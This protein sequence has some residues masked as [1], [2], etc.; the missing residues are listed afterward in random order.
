[1]TNAASQV[2][3]Y[4][5]DEAGNQ[6]TQI[7]AL[8]RT[9]TYAYDGLGRRVSHTLPGGQFEGF[10]YDLAGNQIY[11]TNFNGA[12]ITNQFNAVNRLTNCS[13]INGYHVRFAYSPTGQRTNLIDVSGT[14]TYA[15]DV[16][17][18]LVLK[19]NSWNNGP[20]IALNYS[21]DA[22]GNVTNIWSSTVNG[23]N[24]AYSYDP[25]NRLT[26]VLANGSAAAGY[27]FD[28]AGNLQATRYGNGVTNLC[29]YDSL[30]R[31]TSLTWKLNAG[32]LANFS[33]L[34]G[35]TGNRTNLT[36]SVNGTNRVYAWQ[37]DTL[38]RLTNENFNVSSNLAYAYDVVGNRT[39]R[40][41]SMSS[42]TNQNFT[43]NTND[44]LTTDH[45]DN[46]GN[47]TNSS[48]NAYQYDVMNHLTNLNGTV[49][50]TYDGD[51]NRVS[52]TTGGTNTFYLV[53]DL[54][55]SG[56]A[57]V[58][59]EWT[60]TT[61]ATNVSKVYNYGL[62][63]ISQRAPGTSTNYFV[64]DGHGS[65]RLLV[66][67]GGNVQ[68]LFAYDAYGTLIASNASPQTLYLYSGQ[69][70]DQ[71]LGLYYNRAR[72]L[73]EGTGRFWTM[74]TYAGD[75]EDPLSLHKYLYVW[76][77]PVNHIDPSGHDLGD[78]I[79]SMSIQASMMAVRFA[80]VITV[81]R[82][83]AAT[84]FVAGMTFD[85]EFRDNAMAM[86]PDAL[87]STA[88]EVTAVVFELRGMYLTQRTIQIAAPQA[89]KLGDTI[90]KGVDDDMLVHFAPVEAVKKIDEEGI[91]Y[92]EGG[93]GSHFFKVSEAKNW[94][95]Q[96]AKAAIGDIAGSSV[97]ISGACI[98]NPQKLSNVQQFQ[99]AFWTEY[100]TTDQGIMPDAIIGVTAQ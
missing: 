60:V 73:N 8:N 17:D 11:Q 80:P 99:K 48:G 49:F 67:I 64:Y 78:L 42:L 31:L 89:A 76:G 54:N 57:Q 12:V 83:A 45:Y 23:V 96:Q 16:R 25:L 58:L 61:T 88:S 66:D 63:L 9:N 53:D 87:M 6:T 74:D 34:L 38:Y 90:L 65:T 79:L 21:Y 35:A 50:M 86:G 37:Y 91:K 94:T 10:T 46:N 92:T 69:Q 29:Q 32:S 62:N 5:Y 7:D 82:Y 47:T 2:T 3:R 85:Q 36:E 59:E 93:V 13:S 77:N 4:Q 100:V 39:N 14:T 27:G 30:N 43:F 71:N 22:N 33:Y 68:N 19:T 56:Y 20:G 84:I 55:P 15:Y 95:P 41:S 28:L 98:V 26:N 18:R 44:W 97:D 52:K 75:N 70:F 72:Y 40:T 24:V 51:G 1:V 81:A